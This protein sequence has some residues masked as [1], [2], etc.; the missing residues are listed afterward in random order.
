MREGYL[1]RNKEVGR[2]NFEKW[3]VVKVIKNKK[4][5]ISLLLPRKNLALITKLLL[6][7]LK[8]PAEFWK[9]QASL[10]P[11]GANYVNC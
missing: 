10:R 7:L 3:H 6:N 1:N 11:K 2:G 5:K 8:A 9:F 4:K